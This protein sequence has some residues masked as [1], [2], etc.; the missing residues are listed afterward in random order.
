MQSHRP[1]SLDGGAGLLYITFFAF[2]AFLIASSPGIAAQVTLTWDDLNEAPVEGYNLYYWQSPDD[3][4]TVVKVG[5]QTLFTLTGLEDGRTYFFAVTAV[6]S[7]GTRES[8]FSNVVSATL[9]IAEDTDGDGL[10]DA[11]EKTVYNTNPEV[12]DTDADGIN[13]GD[14]VEF[15]GERWNFDS[16]HDGLVNLLDRDADNDGFI[17]GIEIHHGF[18]PINANLKP[19]LPPLEIGQIEVDQSWVRLSFDERFVDPIVVAEFA[20]RQV[21]EFA[22]LRLRHIDQGGFE[23]RLQTWD[24][25]EVLQHPEM[26]SYL[27]VERGHYILADGTR[28]EADRI[29]TGSDLETVSFMQTFQTLPVLLTSVTSFNVVE[30]IVTRIRSLTAEYFEVAL[31]PELAAQGDRVETIDYLAWDLSSA[32][33]DGMSFEVDTSQSVRGTLT[34][35]GPETDKSTLTVTLTGTAVYHPDCLP[36][37]DVNQD[38]NVT[39]A[40]ALIVFQGFL[41]VTDS[42]L[43]RC[44]LARFNLNDPEG[45]GITPSDAL[46]IF[47]YFLGLPSCLD[48]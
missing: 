13:D 41:G 32:T 43:T 35:S 10:S 44:Q 25:H 18:D 38:G 29:A 8:E 36:D 1:K 42:P 45:S 23:I 39:P 28:V 22:L 16:D 31:Q 48:N 5:K 12:A 26:V 33:V 6:S 19:G 2:F 14:E 34:I 4:P 47:Q 17:D 27:V 21:A 30:A 11:D 3:K 46:C 15:W 37:M 40:D 9:Q 7:N 20:D 24:D